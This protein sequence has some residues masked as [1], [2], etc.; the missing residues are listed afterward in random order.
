[1][2]LKTVAKNKTMYKFYQ[3]QEKI[4]HWDKTCINN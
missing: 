1:M 3:S 4:E 2:Q